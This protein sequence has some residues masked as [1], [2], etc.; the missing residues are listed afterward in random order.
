[1]KI[2]YLTL[3]Q[4]N[5]IKDQNNTEYTIFCIMQDDQTLEYYITY[6]DID[7]TNVF[8]FLWVKDLELSDLPEY[9][10]YKFKLSQ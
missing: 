4:Y 5:Q 3:E 2:A 6:R 1:M 7:L 10:R 9:E 8:D